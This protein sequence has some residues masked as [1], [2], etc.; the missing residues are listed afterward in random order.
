M[1]S[2]KNCTKTDTTKNIRAEGTCTQTKKSCLLPQKEATDEKTSFNTFYVAMFQ[3]QRIKRA[4]ISE[5]TGD[6]DLSNL[7]LGGLVGHGRKKACQ[8]YI[9]RQQTSAKCKEMG[10]QAMDHTN[11]EF[12]ISHPNMFL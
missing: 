8:F 10:S 5:K 6:H 7:K 1:P 9:L 11:T 2:Y 3:R 4:Y 12:Q